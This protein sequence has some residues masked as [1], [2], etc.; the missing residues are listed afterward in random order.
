MFH[1]RH[2]VHVNESCRPLPSDRDSC[3]AFTVIDGAS[4]L[5][6]VGMATLTFF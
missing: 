6:T 3:A 2:R 5:L 1:R 4:L